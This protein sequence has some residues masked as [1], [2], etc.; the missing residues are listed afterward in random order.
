[1]PKKYV[2]FRRLVQCTMCGRQW[3]SE[4]RRPRCWA[5]KSERVRDVS[6]GGATKGAG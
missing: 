2:T 4:V 5:C 3:V 6:V 1:M